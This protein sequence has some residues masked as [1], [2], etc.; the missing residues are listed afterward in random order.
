MRSGCTS[1]V[2]RIE[3]VSYSSSRAFHLDEDLEV[4]VGVHAAKSKLNEGDFDEVA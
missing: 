2:T 1:A 4:L 3:K